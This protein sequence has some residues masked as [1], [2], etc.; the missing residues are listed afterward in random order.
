METILRVCPF[1][2]SVAHI[3]GDEITCC[4]CGIVA[5]SDSENMDELVRL[6]NT[7]NIL[8]EAYGLDFDDRFVSVSKIAIGLLKL[9]ELYN[10]YQAVPDKHWLTTISELA[11]PKE[12]VNN[13]HA[14]TN[15]EN[16]NEQRRN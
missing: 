6:W 12:N 13:N 11:E 10:Q 3:Y 9:I 7:R 14:K 4:G 15:K 2:G 5:K 8:G 1:C 16:R